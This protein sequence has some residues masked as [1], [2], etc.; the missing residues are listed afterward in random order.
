MTGNRP[1]RNRIVAATAALVLAGCTDTPTGSEGAR[2]HPGDPQLLINGSDDF[3]RTAVGAIM[4]YQPNHPGKPG[5]RSFCTGTLIHKRVLMTAGHCV[6]GLER[7]LNSG[8]FHAAWIS[9]QQDP[10]AHFN[11]P[12][13]QADPASGGWYEIESL[14]DN[15]TNPDFSDWE[16][17]LAIHPNFHDSGAIILKEQVKG[18][19]PMRLPSRPGEVEA[20]LGRADCVHGRRLRSGRG[21]VRPAGIPASVHALPGAPVRAAASTSASIRCGCGPPRQRR[22][23]CS[24]QTCFGDSGGPI[25]LQ[26]RNGSD[27]TIVAMASEVEDPLRFTTCADPSLAA[28]SYRVDTKVHLDFINDVILQ[29]LHGGPN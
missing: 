3:E 12:P 13:A 16:N 1:M 24:A 17:Y 14:H 10:L 29:S 20:L 8:V 9:F 7:Q 23:P 21:R 28:L 2:E 5:W 26:K 22:A 4:V 6:Q 25:I 27:R 19:Q 18:I 15:P 11:T